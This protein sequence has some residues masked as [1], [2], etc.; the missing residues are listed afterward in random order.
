MRATSRGPCARLA[1]PT[2]AWRME[3]EETEEEIPYVS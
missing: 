1:D 2:I 3:V